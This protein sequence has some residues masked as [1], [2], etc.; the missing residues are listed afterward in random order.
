MW[1]NTTQKLKLMMNT[2]LGKR[3]RHNVAAETRTVIKHGFVTAAEAE[4]DLFAT[5]T[6]GVKDHKTH[7]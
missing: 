6:S 1:K 5:K 2:Y 3:N 7:V 4:V